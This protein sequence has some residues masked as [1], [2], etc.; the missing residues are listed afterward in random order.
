MSG[1]NLPDQLRH[2]PFEATTVKLFYVPALDGHLIGA[3]I[4]VPTGTSTGW[5]KSAIFLHTDG[6]AGQQF[7]VNE[8]SGSSCLFKRVEAGDIN[9]LDSEYIKLG[10]ANDVTLTWN[11]SALALA[12]LAH[13]TGAFTI[14][15]GS[16]DI[17]I[18][19]FAGAADDYVQLDVGEK[20]LILNDVDL[21]LR[22]N[23]ELQFGTGVD[24]AA[25][26]NST[27]QAL[28][29][30]PTSDYMDI[31][32]LSDRYSLSWIAGQWGK[33]GIN[34]DSEPATPNQAE[35]IVMQQTDQLFEVLGTNASSDD[36]TINAEGG[37]TF[38][39][40]GGDGDEII[41]L[42]HLNA[43]QS[44]WTTVTWDTDQEV[45]WECNIKTGAD[46]T[47]SIIWAGLKKTDTEVMITDTD[48]CF[49]R[50]EDGV[51]SGK[52]EA[53]SSI[54][55]TDDAHDSAV[56]V[57]IN[58]VYHLVIAIQA[59]KTAKMYINGALVETSAVL[60]TVG[61][62]PYIGVAADGA[63]EAKTLH[64]RGQGISRNFA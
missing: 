46:I 11:G 56:T 5:A 44:G 25:V 40:D 38:T 6:A 45:R 21:L 35:I 7:Y 37:I 22:D 63:A 14:G 55:G 29:F 4:T 49:F 60:D 10:T 31:E 17:D 27:R 9:L 13:D 64:V 48:Q 43:S 62:I 58:T 18:K 32:G 23:D 2:A 42:P 15:S 3:G 59:D 20:R 54:S 41:L 24:V 34:A 36:V 19:W 47:N 26:Y 33:P 8:G 39:L 1:H 28:V 12:F 52:W 50:Y 30:K 51:N 16:R 53:I 61:L 57:A